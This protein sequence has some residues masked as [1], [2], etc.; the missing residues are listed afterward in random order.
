MILDH[1]CFILL[2][3]DSHELSRSDFQ[4][5]RRGG[6]QNCAQRYRR[7]KWTLAVGA[8]LLAVSSS[9]L[10]AAVNAA[11][12]K[13][14]RE[15]LQTSDGVILVG[16]LYAQKQKSP[17]VIMLHMLGRSRQA[18]QPLI[19]PLLAQGLTIINID[20]RGH[21]ES[22][23]RKDKSEI[24]YKNFAAS[25]WA[26]LPSDAQ[27]VIADAQKLPGVDGAKLAIIGSSIGAN[28]A[29]MVSGDSHLKALVLLSPGQNYH[30]LQ[31][32]K[33]LKGLEKPV[34]MFAGKGDQDSARAVQ[35]WQKLGTKFKVE[36]LDTQAHGNDLL[37]QR[38]N[39][40]AEIT[41]FLQAELKH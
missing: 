39:V 25:D 18:F 10:A 41:A 30:G 4:Q 27:T 37:T 5:S 13:P 9:L 12:I 15:A 20:L 26:K 3:K 7:P 1:G 23:Y 22:I 2:S 32:E 40:I 14:Q 36:L 16:D 21:G 38:N 34:L 28:T 31:P 6:G 8:L 33:Y 24:S 17:T 19:A 35:Q 11:A 29:A